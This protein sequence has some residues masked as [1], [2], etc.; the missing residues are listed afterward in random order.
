MHTNE[1]ASGHQIYRAVHGAAWSTWQVAQVQAIGPTQTHISAR[2]QATH[3]ANKVSERTACSLKASPRHAADI[4][5]SARR[6]GTGRRYERRPR[7]KGCHTRTR[8]LE[9]WILGHTL[10]RLGQCRLLSH[11]DLCY[12]ST[13][14]A[15]A[16]YGVERVGLAQSLQLPAGVHVGVRVK[17]ARMCE[18]AARHGA[19]SLS[20]IQA[21]SCSIGRVSKC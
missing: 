15:I 21:P 16:W 12:S 2:L 4:L 10:A 11:D 14:A 6:W 7:T 18:A 8:E 19:L 5:C 20:T 13:S 3:C 1:V 9:Q 17:R